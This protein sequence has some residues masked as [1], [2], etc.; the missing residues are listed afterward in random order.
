MLPQ[1]RTR[2]ETRANACS[3]SEDERARHEVS[4]QRTFDNTLFALEKN[5]AVVSFQ[6]VS[7]PSGQ[8]G[9]VRRTADLLALLPPSIRGRHVC[10]SP[11]ECSPPQPP[12]QH[13][14]RRGLS[15]GPKA[16]PPRGTASPLQAAVSPARPA[17]A[18]AGSPHTEGSPRELSGRPAEGRPVSLSPHWSSTQ[19][20]P[21]ALMVAVTCLH[22]A[23][24]SAL[25]LPHS[26]PHPQRGWVG[27]GSSQGPLQWKPQKGRAPPLAN[28][29][30]TCPSRRLPGSWLAHPP[31]LSLSL[32]SEK[33]EKGHSEAWLH[34]SEADTQEGRAAVH[35]GRA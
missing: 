26:P 14:W 20:L 7:Q 2:A 15:G 12:S 13:P 8:A 3:L 18:G 4:S 10:P 1:G 30:R 19:R 9:P 16:R 28:R 32:P 17:C 34:A 23:G 25:R 31:A 22:R 33:A 5:N 11:S 24:G 21:A 6:K 27:H 29:R 35:L